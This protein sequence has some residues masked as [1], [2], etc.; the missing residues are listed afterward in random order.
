MYSNHGQISLTLAVWLAAN[1]GYD[2]VHNPKV[3]SATTLLQPL[4]SMILTR[5]LRDQNIGG[6]VDIS[7]LIASRL[8]TA[9]HTAAEVSWVHSYRI[10]LQNLGYPESMIDRVQINPD[11]TPMPDVIPI[12]M[13]IRS[14]RDVGE[15]T[16]SGKFDF[17][18]EGRVKDIKT[19]KTYNWIKGGNN[20][21]YA[22]QGSIYRWLNPEIIKDDFIDIEFLFTDWSPMKALADKEYPPKQIMTK[23]LPLMSLD[24]TETF[25]CNRL[26]EITAHVDLP[27]EKLPLCTPEELWMNPSK[28]AFYKDATKTTRATKLF[29]SSTEAHIHQNTLGGNGIVV[30]R[31]G[32]PTFCKYCE[33]RPICVQAEQF[34]ASGLLKI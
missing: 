6:S 19:T 32:E 22:I 15:Y 29:D 16:I 5:R 17:V 3:F 2:L 24:A 31:K 33:A 4:R 11:K 21:K 20:K 8:G 27:Q 30:E 23:T 34:I 1:D 9:V 28:W 13:E 18:E 7:S 14:E 26:D 10:A 12:Y 25:I